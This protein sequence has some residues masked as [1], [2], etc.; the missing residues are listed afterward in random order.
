MYCTT[1][2]APLEAAA[3]YCPKCGSLQSAPGPPPAAPVF[4]PRTGIRSD[5]GRWIGLGWD[6]VKNDL[7]T[8]VLAGLIWIVL[9]SVVPILL[10]G[11]LT[12]GFQVLCLNRLQG[13][14]GEL[15]DIFKGFDFF[16]PAMLAGLLISVFVS[17]G[18][19][20]CIIPGIVAAAVC[21]FAYLFVMDK[22]MDFWPAI[23]ASYEIVRQDYFGFTMFV[24]A[25]GLLNLLGALALVVGLLI[26]VPLSMAATA[27]AYRDIVGPA[28]A[29]AA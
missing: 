25:L 10:V 27:A 24:V 22:R 29:P 3:R 26:T 11:P 18:A 12:A 5:T 7:G 4:A 8:F 6:V 1:C 16:V 14:R 15:G 20:L 9:N 13:R 2:G 19:L 21:Q 28:E 17:V 23:Q